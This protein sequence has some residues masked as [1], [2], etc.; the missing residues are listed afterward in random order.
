MRN[1]HWPA[2]I[3]GGLEAPSL[4][5]SGRSRLFPLGASLLGRHLRK[6]IRTHFGPGAPWREFATM[7]RTSC[8]LKECLQCG[9]AIA[10]EALLFVLFAIHNKVVRKRTRSRLAIARIRFAFGSVVRV[11]V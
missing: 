3:R 5:P 10:I 11:H 6:S 1:G 8:S 7:L 2:R 9:Q 4:R